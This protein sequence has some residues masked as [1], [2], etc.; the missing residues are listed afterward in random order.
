MWLFNYN[1]YYN[2]WGRKAIRTAES[3]FKSDISH[4]I[5]I[6]TYNNY[7]GVHKWHDISNSNHDI[8][9]DG[10]LKRLIDDVKSIAQDQ[11]IIIAGHQ[12]CDTNFSGTKNGC[13]IDTFSKKN[14]LLF[15]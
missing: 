7:S 6:T 1:K 15:I 3:D 11:N 4:N 12:Y 14:R 2:L 13:D 10:S 9:G 8:S 5:Y